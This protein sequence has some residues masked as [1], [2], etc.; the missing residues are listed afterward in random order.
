MEEQLNA[1]I[2]DKYYDESLSFW[3]CGKIVQLSDLRY[4]DEQ[5]LSSPI[6]YL[7]RHSAE[8]LIKALII[9]DA[10]NLYGYDISE[11]K[12]P[13]HNRLLTSM[14]SLKALYDTWQEVLSCMM[15]NPIDGELNKKIQTIIQ[16]VDDCDPFSTFFRYPYDKE[17]QE[18]TKNFTKP[19]E[20]NDLFHLPCSIGAIIHH[21]GIEKF[22]CWQG[23]DKISWLE[24]DL[25]ILISKLNL[26][27]KGKEILSDISNNEF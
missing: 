7:F 5:L 14:H 3:T 27:Y 22:S 8:L 4:E 12:F 24:I 9:R 10:I 18:N 23:D 17:G 13:P 1:T 16:R 2:N 6:I 26:L 21:E 15:V 20:E 11:V 19:A 25:D